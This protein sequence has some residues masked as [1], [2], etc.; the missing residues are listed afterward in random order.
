[1]KK[2]KEE[3]MK[4]LL[5]ITLVAGLVLVPLT[6]LAAAKTAPG[7]TNMVPKV[8]IPKNYL[9]LPVPRGDLAEVK[10][11]NTLLDAAVKDEE[12]KNIGTIDN[13][14]V[15]TKTGKIAYAVVELSD[16]DRLVPVPW[17]SL[18]VDRSNGKV[19]L[20]GMAADLRPYLNQKLLEDQSPSMTEIMKEVKE[21]RKSIPADRS[22]LGIT[23]RPSAA[24]P[25]GEAKT[26]GAG[27][28]GPRGISP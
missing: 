8:E 3:I 16:T 2:G 26:G 27:P 18:S 10:A 14:I 15:D 23:E 21:V 11:K 24:G 17:N 20:N 1:M 25:M 7:Q 5:S 9:I 12:G 22:G 13:L 4:R 6:A 28:S 19:Q